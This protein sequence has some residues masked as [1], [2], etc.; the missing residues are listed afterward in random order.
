MS[1]LTLAVDAMGGDAG[2]SVVVPATLRYLG[3][4]PDVGVIV[5]GERRQLDACLARHQPEAIPRFQVEYAAQSVADD[6]VPS[7]ALRN[8]KKS[9]LWAALAA[10]AERRADACVSGGNTGAMMAMAIK[11]LG[12]ESLVDR[13]AICTPLPG[14]NGSCYA[15]DM[16]AN[17][18]CTPVQLHQFARMGSVLAQRSSAD[19]KPSIA[20]LNVG[21]EKTKGNKLVKQ[22]AEL[23]SKDASLSYAGFVEPDRLFSGAVEADVVVCDGFV[24]NVM[25]KVSEGIAETIIAAL[26]T[27]I[28][29]SLSSQLGFILAKKSFEDFKKWFD[30]S[31]YGGSPLLGVNGGVIISHGR[32][33]AKAIKNALRAAH[34]L[35]QQK[36]V[37]NL[38]HNLKESPDL[39]TVGKKHGLFD[40]VFKK[41]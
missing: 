22:A 17:V 15:L 21:T 27:E 26:K 29:K 20:L 40:K 33:S 19:R 9:S 6:E 7:A 34:E 38:E 32:S 37:E 24:G 10:V 23:I 35:F 25:L 11:L 14:I 3:D 30:Y 18:D 41:D 36:V 12:V 1:R 13:P 28:Q 39:H 16:G 4:N 5:F 8:K 2:P 31:N